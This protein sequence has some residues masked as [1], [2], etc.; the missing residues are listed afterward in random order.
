MASCFLSA[1]EEA[2][3]LQ[4]VRVQQHRPFLRLPVAHV[5]LSA[6]LL[7]G[8]V[9]FAV[10]RHRIKMHQRVLFLE[11]LC[12]ITCLPTPS[13]VQEQCLVTGSRGLTPSVQ[14]QPPA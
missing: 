1:G 10:T 9:T 11:T 8:R 4:N 3:F 13:Q 12:F 7:S 2:P 5:A 6:W 14:S